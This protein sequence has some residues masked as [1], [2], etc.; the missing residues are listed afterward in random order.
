MKSIKPIIKSSFSGQIVVNLR[1]QILAGDLKPGDKLPPERELARQF[2]TNRNTL[3]EAIR[4][5]EGL[6]LITVRQGDGI[7]I[8]DFRKEAEITILPYFIVE[9]GSD[10]ERALVL[11]DILALRRLTLAETASLAAQRAE[12]T[13]ITDLKDHLKM[14]EGALP[15]GN[16]S[17]LDLDFYLLLIKASHSQAS[18]WM[19]NTFFDFYRK[20]LPMIKEIWVTPPDYLK[21]LTRLVAAI[22]KRHPERASKIIQTHLGKGDEILLEKITGN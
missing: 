20:A 7:R 18:T 3:R 6:K 10:E 4:S 2:G 12:A 5:L 19:L 14:I 16:I 22:Q 17:D 8:R 15:E 9:G 1:R 11:S 21:S 13:D